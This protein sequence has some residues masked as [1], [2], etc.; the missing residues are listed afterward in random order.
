MK[1]LVIDVQTAIYTPELF[2]YHV[3]TET[4]K[5]L[6]ETARQT[7]TEVLYLRHNDGAGAPLSPEH[8]GFAIAAPFAPEKGERVFD[9]TVNSPFRSSGLLQYLR[10]CRETELIVTGLQTEYCVDAAVKCG[11]EHGFRMIVP[12]YANTTLD[13]PHLTAEQTYR[14]YNEFIWNRRYAECI[15]A[16]ETVVRMEQT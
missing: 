2:H 1:L 8:P 11:F 6:L 15:P 4:L 3:F 14:Y 12:A 5:I 9:K 16:G 7:G 13:N 10:T